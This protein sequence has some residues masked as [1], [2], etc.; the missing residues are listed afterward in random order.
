MLVDSG[1]SENHVDPSFT[2]GVRAHM[3]DNEDLRIPLPIIATGQHVLHGVTTGFL[4]GKVA[5]D[6]GHDR[7]VSFRVVLVPGLGTNLVSVTS[8]PSP[9]RC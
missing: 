7:Q 2:P 6:G 8:F 4:F 1:A 5:D 9:L 3:R